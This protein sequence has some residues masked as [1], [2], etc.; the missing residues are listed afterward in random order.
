[1]CPRSELAKGNP[2]ETLTETDAG[3]LARVHE[4]YRTALPESAEARQWLASRGLSDVRVL[5]RFEVG[6]AAGVLKR[7]LPRDVGIHRSLRNLGLIHGPGRGYESL[8]GSIVIPIHDAH[9]AVVAL[10]GYPL[11]GGPPKVSGNAGGIFNTAAMKAHPSIHLVEDP[12]AALSR[13]MGGDEAVVAL[14]EGKW[15][16][17]TDSIFR[18]HAPHS[19]VVEKGPKRDEIVAHLKELGVGQGAQVE[20]AG[21]VTIENGFVASF[22]RRRYTVQSVSRENPRHLRALVRAIG[23]TP[24]RFHLD[25]LDLYSARDRANFVREGAVLFGE[26]AALVEADLLRI[27]MMAEE[28]LS[29]QPGSSGVIMDDKTCKEALELLRSP[30]LLERILKDFEELGVVGEEANKLAGYLV[31]TSRKLDDPLSM[32][33][34]SRSAAGKSTLAD[35]LSLLTPPEEVVRLTRVTGQGLFYQ[36]GT[37]LRN[38]LLVM[39]E[40]AGVTAAAYALRILQS[41]RKLALQTAHGSHEVEGPVAVILTT[42]RTKL[43]DETRGRFLILSAD[44]SQKQTRAILEA[45]RRREAG[46]FSQSEGIVRIHHALQRC[47]RPLRVINPHASHLTFADHRLGTRREQPKYLALIR[48]VTFLRQFQRT[49]ENGVIQVELEDI[50]TAHRLADTILGQNLEDVSPPARRL[51]EALYAWRPKGRFTRQEARAALQWPLTQLWTY[52]GELAQHEWILDRGGRPRQFELAW[53]GR[54]GKICLGLRSITELRA[55]IG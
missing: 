40:E 48:A 35:A 36:K 19:V 34:L 1:M 45:Q 20:Q 41:A 18:Q 31:A 52:M 24:G 32:L 46:E 6:Y 50:E 49:E 54:E 21:E 53:D 44:E 28:W 5:E 23:L 25:A 9:G 7:I 43:D 51:L 55:L 42:T 47:L 17:L 8:V 15:T 33:I 11:A 13:V 14:P 30:E 16:A 27:V 22:G 29:R 26:D 3:L 4:I 12:L 37:S 2:M 38:K 10:V 39:E